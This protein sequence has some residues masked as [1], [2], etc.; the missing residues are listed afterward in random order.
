MG[1]KKVLHISKYFPP[2]K[3]GIEDICKSIVESLSEYKNFVF[4]YNDDLEDS[5]TN[6]NGIEILRV[7]TYFTAFSQPIAPFYKYKLR[8]VIESY[9]P[10]II[11][12]H[13]PNPYAAYTVSTLKDKKTKL[14]VHWHSDIINQKLIYPLFSFLEKRIL[15]LADCIFVTSPN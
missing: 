12:L 2:Y 13:L 11:H 7:S 5:H 6:E 14:I 1:P 3:G 15:T 8:K 9:Q 4:C 10:D